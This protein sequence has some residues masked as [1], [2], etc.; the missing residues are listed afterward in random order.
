M[1]KNF[2]PREAYAAYI[3]GSV[4]VDVRDNA[5]PEART[6]DVNKM[7]KLPYSELDQRYGELPTNRPVI[8]LSRVGNKGKAAADFLLQHGYQDVAILDGGLDAWVQ[9]GLPVKSA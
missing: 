7:F 5:D 9:E 3:L 4:L 6:L 1:V 2:S 8:L